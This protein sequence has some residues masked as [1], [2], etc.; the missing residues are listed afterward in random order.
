MNGPAARPKRFWNSARTDSPVA[1]TPGWTTSVTTAETGPTV[2]VMMNP[3]IA[4]S[5]NWVVNEVVAAKLGARTAAAA[6]HSAAIANTLLRSR[7]PPARSTTVPHTTL[8]TAPHR[9]TSAAWTP[10]LYGAMPWT[11]LRKLGSQ[12]HTAETTMSWDAPPRQTQ[13]IVGERASAFTTNFTVPAVESVALASVGVK[14][15]VL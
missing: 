1:R 12:A 7:R 15:T 5:A 3:P 13:S 8:P 10:A 2:Q 4:M 14:A 6:T 11:R 9:T